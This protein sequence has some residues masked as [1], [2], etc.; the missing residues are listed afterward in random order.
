M[1]K[2]FFA[3]SF[4]NYSTQ[5]SRG[6]AVV[7]AIYEL[8]VMKC[9]ARKSAGFSLKYKTSNAAKPLLCAAKII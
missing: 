9:V 4:G 1:I 6:L 7:A 8:F 5:R 2:R 3:V